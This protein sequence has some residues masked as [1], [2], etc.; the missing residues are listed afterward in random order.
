MSVKWNKGF[1]PEVI[2][3]KLSSIRTLDGEQVSFNS[4]D[5]E[6]LITAL[7]SMIDVDENISTEVSNELIVKGFHEA[8]KKPKL[9]KEAIIS[10][11]KKVIREHLSKPDEKFSLVTTLNIRNTDDLPTYK[12]NNCSLF[13][14]KKLPQKYKQTRQI[15]LKLA[16][17]WLIGKDD[18]FSYYLVVHTHEK[19][20][21]DAVAK[22]LDTVNL[23]RGIWNLHTN[24]TLLISFGGQ[25]KPI[26][27]V[28]LGPIHT[29]HNKYGKKINDIYWYEPNYF[30]ERSLVAFSDRSYITL[31]FTKNVRKALNK[32]PYRNDVEKA[33]IRYVDA[34]DSQDYNSVFLKLW[35]ILEYLTHTMKD[36]YDKTIKRAS[37][38]FKDRDYDTQV[39]KH[40]RQYRNK[41]V[42][43]GV[44]DS[45]I[46]IHVYQL[47]GYVEQLLRFHIS[48]FYN[49]STLEDAAKFMDLPHDIN[50]LNKQIELYQ[51]GI[52]FIGV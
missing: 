47:K 28:Q 8:S 39:L 46:D 23:L 38:H 19:S 29:L 18:P 44:G 43:L 40:L 22:M 4:F 6:K 13:F 32:N 35:S 10:S 7:K 14:Y 41:S 17:T 12:I 15:F 25:K 36:S 21:H 34:L 1:Q 9:T 37:F 11:I 26:N 50:A 16:S 33:I 31:E 24:P 5:Y 49:F 45:D 48:N 3:S 2:V 42:H 52:K 30:K 20:S 27:Q 51:N